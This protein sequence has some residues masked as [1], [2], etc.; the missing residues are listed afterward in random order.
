MKKLKINL[1]VKYVEPEIITL[2][3]EGERMLLVE[4]VKH[5]EIKRKVIYIKR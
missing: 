5:S 2:C 3:Y 1:E 4:K